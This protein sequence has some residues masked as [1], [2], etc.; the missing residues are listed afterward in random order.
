MAAAPCTGTIV[1]GNGGLPFPGRPA[2]GQKVLTRGNGIQAFR[3]G[4]SKTIMVAESK[5]E[6]FTSWYS[7]LASY[8]VA[9]WPTTGA[10]ML[11]TTTNTWDCVSPCKHSLNRGEAPDFYQTTNPHKT[12][13]GN[14]HTWGPSSNHS[15]VVLH[16]FA[17]GHGESVNN[18]VE[19]SIYLHMVTIAGREVDNPQ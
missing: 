15:G 13:T 17:D 12:G 2:T 18:T 1:C 8:V 9:H 4:T 14:E 5:E 16:T 6:K 3:D 7:G 11:N 10:P 19:G